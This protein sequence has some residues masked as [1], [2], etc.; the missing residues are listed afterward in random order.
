MPPSAICINSC[1]CG[2]FGFLFIWHYFSNTLHLFHFLEPNQLSAHDDFN[3]NRRKEQFKEVNLLKMDCTAF[4]CCP[5]KKTTSGVSVW[6]VLERCS[7]NSQLSGNYDPLRTACKTCSRNYI[8]RK[9]KPW[10]RKSLLS[11]RPRWTWFNILCSLNLLLLLASLSHAVLNGLSRTMSAK[12]TSR[13]RLHFLLLVACFLGGIFLPLASCQESLQST[14]SVKS[15]LNNA[16]VYVGSAFSY[17]ISTSVFDCEVD[18]I[19]VS[20]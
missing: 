10:R 15:Q 4:S 13:L 2:D 9:C 3:W 14:P 6:A 17:N 20:Y 19:V 5:R 7:D 18:S 8:C 12:K 1:I 11:T 16:I